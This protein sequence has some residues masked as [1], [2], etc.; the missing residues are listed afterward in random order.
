M[1]ILYFAGGCFWGMEA[2]LQL[3]DGVKETSCGYANGHT[4]DPTYEAVCNTDT[5]FAEAVKVTY[6]PAILPL[7]KLLQY[8][9]RVIDPTLYHRQG[10]DIGEQYRTG[11]YYTQP[12]E[13]EILEGFVSS[14][15]NNYSEPILT[16]IEPLQNYYLA[17]DYH[18]RYLKKNPTGY[19]HIPLK[20]FTPID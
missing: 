13:K 18:Q 11:I 7:T 15:Q 9:F 3:I 5:G 19:C 2:Y 16:E 20:N 12:E 8:F 17:E 14:I 10:F 6:D 1:N 4:Q